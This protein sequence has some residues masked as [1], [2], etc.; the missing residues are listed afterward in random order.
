LG[1]LCVGLT[2]RDE[3]G[4]LGGWGCMRR[5]CAL[6]FGGEQR[7]GGRPLLPPLVGSCNTS[8]A[9]SLITFLLD[10]DFTVSLHGLHRNCFSPEMPMQL[11]LAMANRTLSPLSTNL[12][13]TV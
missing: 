6:I 5:H 3:W 2:R 7:A 4:G 12:G 13:S 11:L 1:G 10:A 8:G 9:S